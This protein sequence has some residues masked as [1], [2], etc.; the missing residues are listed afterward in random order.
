[1]EYT[2][3]ARRRAQGLSIMATAPLHIQYE[4]RS[5]PLTADAQRFANQ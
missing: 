2:V 5:D 4:W 3:V 1:M